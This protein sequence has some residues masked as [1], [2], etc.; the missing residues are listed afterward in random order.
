[1]T[2]DLIRATV[3]VMWKLMQEGFNTALRVKIE[4]QGNLW[5]SGK[6]MYINNSYLDVTNEPVKLNNCYEA[7]F[8]EG[9]TK[10]RIIADYVDES[11]LIELIKL[12]VEK[13]I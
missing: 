1:M 6:E 11:R 7:V 13:G 8:Y 5:I 3:R 10:I 9:E 4:C 12:I 2:K